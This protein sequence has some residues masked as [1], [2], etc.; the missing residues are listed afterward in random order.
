MC[1][2]YRLYRT[3]YRAI[4]QNVEQNLCQN[5][6]QNLWRKIEQKWRTIYRIQGTSRWSCARRCSVSSNWRTKMRCWLTQ[7]V[8]DCTVLESPLQSVR[9]SLCVRERIGTF[10]FRIRSGSHE[11]SRLFAQRVSNVSI[12]WLK[13][14]SRHQRNPPEPDS[15]PFLGHLKALPEQWRCQGFNWQIRCRVGDLIV[16]T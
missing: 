14:H 1:I 10:R 12:F 3:K 7:F 11:I 2:T 16:L 8:T 4:Y 5:L 6:R 15:G 13:T 9:L